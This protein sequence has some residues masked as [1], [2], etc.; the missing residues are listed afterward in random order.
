MPNAGLVKQYAKEQIL[1]L[2]QNSNGKND[3]RPRKYRK[4]LSGI[5]LSDILDIVLYYVSLQPD[6]AEFYSMDSWR[7]RDLLELAWKQWMKTAEQAWGW[8]QYEYPI[9]SGQTHRAPRFNEIDTVRQGSSDSMPGIE[10]YAV[11]EAGFCLNNFL[12]AFFAYPKGIPYCTGNWPA[13]RDGHIERTVFPK[14][15]KKQNANKLEAVFKL[16][17]L[18]CSQMRAL[19]PAR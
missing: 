13:Y 19:R 18:V 14:W 4:F 8:K 2:I 6:V 9:G 5:F 16:A 1:R 3:R 7:F 12:G 10:Q 11:I 15:R 17:E